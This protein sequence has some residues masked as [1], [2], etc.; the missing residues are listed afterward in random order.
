V[1]VDRTLVINDFV[2][3]EGLSDSERSSFAGLG[4]GAL[5]SATLR[6]GEKVPLWSICAVS[7]S[8]RTWT[9]G[10]VA[11]VEEVTERTWA[12][13]EKATAEEALHRSESKYRTLFHSIDEGVLSVEVL[14]DKAGKA[15]DFR[16]L[17]HNPALTKQTGMTDDIVGKRAYV[18]FPEL[19]PFWLETLKRVIETGKS[20]RHEVH[21]PSINQWLDVLFSPVKERASPKVVCVYNNITVRKRQE[22]NLAFLARMNLDFGPALTVPKVMEQVGMQLAN[23]LQLSRCHFSLVDEKRDRVEVIYEFRRDE[24]VPSLTGTHPLSERLTEEG[25][26]HYRAGKLTIMDAAVDSPLLKTPAHILK[27]HGFGSLVEVPHLEGGYWKFLLTAG[28]AQAGAWQSDEVE[29]LSE[30]ASK[31]YIRIERARAEQALQQLTEELDERVKERTATLNKTTEE[32]QK[33]LA[34]LQQAEDLA[35]VGS[36]DYNFVNKDFTWSKGMYDLFGLQQD[37]EVKPEIYSRFAVS[38]DKYVAEKIARNIRKGEVPLPG[39]VCIEVGGSTKV[40]QLEAL[41]I[42]DKDGKPLKIVGVDMDITE[43]KQAE[44]TLS[45]Q[46][47][48]IR[49]INEA[50]PDILYVIDLRTEKIIYI[51][52]SFEEQLG[53]S[54]NVIQTSMLHLLFEEDLPLM[55]SHLE[56]I[57]MAPDGVVCEVEYRLK[58]ADGSLHW[59]RDRNSVFKRDKQGRALEKIGIAQDVTARKKAE[60]ELKESNTSLRYANENL[61]QFAS[62]ASHDLQ[63]PLRKLELFASVLKGHKESLPEAAKEVIQKISRTSGRM[64]QLITEVLQYSKV[65]YATKEFVRTDLH[66]IF[67]SVVSDLD[68]LIGETSA[69]VAYDEPLP[70]I[71]AVPPQMNQLF[72]NLLT[73]ALKFRVDGVHPVVTISHRVLPASEV[74]NHP[75]LSVEAPHIEIRFRDNGVG[76]KQTYAEQ[77]FQLFERLYSVDQYEGTG[78][79]L[80]L[81]K[82]IV[83]NHKGHIHATSSDG[84]GATF[85][86]LMPVQQAHNGT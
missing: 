62:I 53:F 15:V 70:A 44:K 75:D 45:D 81:C 48:F 36:W 80:A 33:N 24:G 43:V 32:L 31:I 2:K 46:A 68:V 84:A 34:I 42:N 20:E 12:A 9:G 78:L 85:F 49:S 72:Y 82:K 1:A 61:Q 74:K 64:R 13:L 71:E 16:Y 60:Q 57:R 77:I 76:F 52:H 65:A 66:S 40:L 10:E 7:T 41:L 8:P 73:N 6:K 59:F 19:E 69:F 83:E 54:G 4:M 63:E 58:A 17:E 11:L 47:H 51:N 67:Q 28:R 29:L 21:A 27:R 56:E 30:L 18:L 38:E 37:A 55:V 5:I 25:R 50:L 23:H 14:F 86:V 79:G 35:L 3:M 39:T 26:M 22:A